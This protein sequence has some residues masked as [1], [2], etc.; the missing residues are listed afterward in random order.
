MSYGTEPSVT[1][2]ADGQSCL[3][4]TLPSDCQPGVSP[5][6]G[7]KLVPMPNPAVAPTGRFPVPTSG[8]MPIGYYYGASPPGYHYAAPA[9]APAYWYS[10]GR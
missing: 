6:P 4:P 2:G 8:P 3:T 5:T 9:A 1:V 7:G 10:N